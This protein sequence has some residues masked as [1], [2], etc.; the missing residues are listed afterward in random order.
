[1]TKLLGKQSTGPVPGGV[2]PVFG[3]GTGTALGS[4]FSTTT[5]FTEENRVAQRYL[6]G[7]S[8]GRTAFQVWLSR[9]TA[10]STDGFVICKIVL[11]IGLG[12]NQEIGQFPVHDTK[13]N[14][15]YGFLNYDVGGNQIGF[16]ISLLPTGSAGGT[17]QTVLCNFEF[18][19]E[20]N[21]APLTPVWFVLSATSGGKCHVA[22]DTNIFSDKS[23]Y[24][25]RRDSILGWVAIPGGGTLYR[26][27]LVGRVRL[28][29]GLSS[30]GEAFSGENLGSGLTA[31]DPL[32]G[33]AYPFTSTAGNSQKV[34]TVDF[35]TAIIA[36]KDSHGHIAVGI[37]CSAGAEDTSLLT[38]PGFSRF[39]YSMGVD[40]SSGG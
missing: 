27:Q 28:Q 25:M 1:M 11:G 2:E 15:Q 14:F 29:R 6:S 8:A 22:C 30:A 13:S 32:T 21:F 7:S 20:G 31:W 10:S 9:D 26:Q 12:L 34:A 37:V 16:P 33:K 24:A 38:P 35:P 17:G 23:N 4:T 19:I 40:F 18:E 36:R 5:D 3:W 39:D